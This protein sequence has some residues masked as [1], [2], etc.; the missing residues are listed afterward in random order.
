[1][2]VQLRFRP[3]TEGDELGAFR[4]S[5]QQPA[6]L[7][8]LVVLRGKGAPTTRVK[9]SLVTG[10]PRAADVLLVVDSSCSF[11]PQRASLAANFDWLRTPAMNQGVDVRIA[12]TGSESE[13]P[14]CPSC[15]NGHFFASDGGVRVITASTPSPQAHVA[16]WFAGLLGG[17]EELVP[18]AVNAFTAPNVFDPTRSGGLLRDQA[19]L[20]VISLSDFPGFGAPMA[21][22]LAILRGVKGANRPE[23]FSFSVIDEPAAGCPAPM[24]SPLDPTVIAFGGVQLSLCTN[25]WPVAL[26]QAG[27]VAA[28]FRER[29]WLTGT[30]ATT[31]NLVVSQGGAPLANTTYQFDVL[32]NSIVLPQTIATMRGTLEVSYDT[33]CLP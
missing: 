12:A 27:F 7:E 1:M 9:E 5:V 18:N 10:L 29:V 26:Q 11:V 19:V 13:V 33:L 31:P 23:R 20:G 8:H 30:P 22:Q 24:P 28:G 16:S 4:V 6:P 14:G 3:Q 32:T 21:W 15:T 25:T 2:S 17:S